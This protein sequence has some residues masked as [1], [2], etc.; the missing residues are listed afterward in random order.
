MDIGIV[1]L[2]M[3]GIYFALLFS[4]MAAKKYFKINFCVIC[5]TVVTTWI[6]LFILKFINFTIDP[7]IPAILMGESVVGAMYALERYAQ[8]HNNEK[9]LLLKPVMI[10]AGT[11]I[12][13]LVITNVF[14]RGLL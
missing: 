13:Y 5:G 1:L 12:I 10:I 9:L 14:M 7:I 4:S 3:L 8:G 6:V 2:M 11:G